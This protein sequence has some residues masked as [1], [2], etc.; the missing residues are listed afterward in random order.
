MRPPL[1]VDGQKVTTLINSGAQVSSISSRL[2]EH[3][4]LKV[5]PLGRLLE[6]EGTGGSAIL[7]LGYIEFNLWIPGIKSY[8]EDVL[9]LVMP[10]TTYSKKVPVM[11]GSKSI[12]RAIGM[13]TK[14]EL[15]RATVTCKQAHFNVVMS[16]SLQ[17]PHTDSKGNRGR[18]GGHPSTGS[19]PTTPMNF[20]LDDVWEPVHTIPLSGTIS[21]RSNTGIQGHCMKVHVLAEPAQGPQLPTSMV[22]TATY[23]E[24]HPGSS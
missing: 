3:M 1:I 22:P 9:L 8:N 19:D 17:L 5:H 12:D 18:E 20:C 13:M 7:Y 10:T 2:C 14:G 16:G 4:T 23:G 21:I 6:L 15:M 24:L 11:V